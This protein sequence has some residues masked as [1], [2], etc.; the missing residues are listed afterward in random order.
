MEKILKSKKFII[1][2]SIVGVF[3]VVLVS[4]GM[5]VA[6]GFHKAKFSSH[7]G[8]NYERN[9]MG[10]RPDMMGP[11]GPMVIMRERMREFE[12]KGLRNGHGVAGTIISISDNN[13]VIKDRDNK[14]NTIS[15]GDKTIIKQGGSDI[16]ISDLKNDE[17]IVV[18]GKPGEDG[19]VNADLIRVFDKSVNQ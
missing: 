4:F 9:F 2:A 15:V 3:I 7:F 11:D 10:P 16:K 17:E 8:E 14:E 13:I 6:V 19:V 5:G 1:A 18:I 12:G